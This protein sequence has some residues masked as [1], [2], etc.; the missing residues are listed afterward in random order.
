MNKI[1]FILILAVS[2]VMVVAGEWSGAGGTRVSSIVRDRDREKEIEINN[3]ED[4]VRSMDIAE[5]KLKNGLVFKVQPT[6]LGTLLIRA[7]SSP[8]SDD[9]NSSMHDGLVR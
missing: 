6:D 2:N 5:I 1:F 8:R 9:F 3:L 7:V 4:A